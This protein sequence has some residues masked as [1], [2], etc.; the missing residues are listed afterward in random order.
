MFD[1]LVRI[2]KA[3][4]SGLPNIKTDFEV[5]NGQSGVDVKVTYT[6]D[7]GLL[8]SFVISI[9]KLKDTILVHQ[10][11]IG[12]GMTEAF[13]DMIPFAQLEDVS[14][15]ANYT[16]TVDLGD[17]NIEV[18]KTLKLYIWKDVLCDY[19]SGIIFAMA[20]TLAQARKV[21]VDCADDWAR[22]SVAGAVIKSDPEIHE[23]PYGFF[24]Y[25]GS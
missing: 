17:F 19:T 11:K 12:A 21:V 24:I 2:P 22:E 23:S 16:L 8:A 15:K 18:E 5:I 13:Q 7:M 10:L 9:S 1:L 3:V 25:G 6:N 4:E 20:Y 14:V